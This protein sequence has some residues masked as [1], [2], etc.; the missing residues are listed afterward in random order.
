M[1]FSST[2][3]IHRRFFADPVRTDGAHNAAT[4]RKA[5]AMFHSEEEIG[6]LSSAP[7]KAAIS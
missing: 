7:V 3:R 1:S 2:N 6:Y 4:L 5:T